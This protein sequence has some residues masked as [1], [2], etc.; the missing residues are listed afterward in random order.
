MFQAESEEIPALL[1]TR[2]KIILASAEVLSDKDI[3][4][5]QQQLISILNDEIVMIIVI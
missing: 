5:W 4:V 3:Q 1:R 2:P